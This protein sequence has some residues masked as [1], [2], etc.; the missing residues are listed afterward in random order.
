[1]NV[2]K[3]S[4]SMSAQNEALVRDYLGYSA[5]G[6]LEATLKRTWAEKI[7]YHGRELGEIKTRDDLFAM[8]SRFVGAMPDMVVEIE[9]ML[10]NDEYVVAVVCV[11]GTQAGDDGSGTVLGSGEK[12]EF[13]SIDMWRIR[14]GRLAE[15][16][17][18]EGLID[19]NNPER[20][21]LD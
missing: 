21:R 8:L 12:V 4:T 13:R 15:Q 18:V 11:T 2:G 10:S 17:I 5:R 14:D 16:W 7:A 1:M 9:T 3:P 20:A 6:D 19:H